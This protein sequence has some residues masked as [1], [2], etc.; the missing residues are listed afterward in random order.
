[1][2]KAFKFRLYPTK[3]Q[4]T[5]INKTI[6]CCRYMYNHFLNRRI[7]LYRSEQNGLAYTGCCKELIGLKK[8]LPWLK[9]VDSMAL[10]QSL[11]DLDSA[12][13]HFFRTKAGFPKF[14]S[15]KHPSRATVPMPMGAVSRLTAITS[16]YRNWVGL[17]LPSPG[18]SKDKF[19]RQP[20]AGHPPGN[21]LFRCCV[22]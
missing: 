2:H 20:C 16:N 8:E 19:S 12:Y 7:N 4:M 11:K 18:K 17:S 1:M 22:T 3:E 13:K 5:L 21:T 14:K 6:G 9:E 15:K 10:Q